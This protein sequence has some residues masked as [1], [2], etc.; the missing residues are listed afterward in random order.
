MALMIAAAILLLLPLLLELSFRLLGLGPKLMGMKV[1]VPDGEIGF[2]GRPHAHYH[3]RGW[4]GEF[5]FLCEH[6]AEGFRDRD[7]SEAKPEGMFRIMCVGDSYIYGGGVEAGDTYP[8]RLE[9]RLN[10]VSSVPIEVMN[11]G[12]PSYYVRQMRMCLERMA[13][14]YRP[15]LILAA[16]LPLHV[17]DADMGMST[18]TLSSE[19]YLVWNEVPTIGRL[20]NYL[21]ARSRLLQVVLEK[22]LKRRRKKIFRRRH[23][24]K[25][26]DL[27][28]DGG[29]FEPGWQALEE[30]IRKMK[31]AAAAAGARF[32]LV[33]IPE[34]DFDRPLRDYPVARLSA[35]CAREAIP[36]VSAFEAIARASA[37]GSLYFRHD[38]H[39]N[40]RGYDV[41]AESATAEL[42]RQGLIPADAVGPSDRSQ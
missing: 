29:S 36:F 16:V 18:F 4:T 38:G 37:Q 10:A 11:L 19:G 6:N 33:Y 13:P 3:A 14:R 15:D 40:A 26:E 24:V 17:V 35:W 20:G 27:F 22:P 1:L 42:K 12:L 8:A 41:V 30:E 2:R 7:H 25:R 28:A 32:A 31:A 34:I 23:P 5:A 21:H 9:A 39:L